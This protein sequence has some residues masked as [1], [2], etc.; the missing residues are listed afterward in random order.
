MT[1]T[2]RAPLSR[3]T[4]LSVNTSANYRATYYSR[5][6]GPTGGTVSDPYFRQYMS[7]HT[8]VVGPVFTR[9][10]DRPTS[11]FAER[12]KHVI[13]PAFSVDM[14]SRIADFAKTPVVS[15]VSEFVIGSAAQLT[16]G[17]TNRLFARG[18]DVGVTRGQTREFLTVGIQQT[19]YTNPDSIRYDSAYQSTFGY[20]FQRDRSPVALTARVSPTGTYRRQPSRG[21]RHLRSGATVAVGRRR[22]QFTKGVVCRQLQLAGFERQQFHV[23]VNYPALVGRAGERDVFSQ[24]G[25]RAVLRREPVDC[26]LVSGA[27]LRAPGRISEIQLPR[28]V[29]Y[30]NRLGHAFQFRVRPRRSGDVLEL[31]RRIRRAVRIFWPARQL[32]FAGKEGMTTPVSYTSAAVKHPRIAGVKTKPLRLIPDERGW[33]MEILRADESELFTKFGQVYVSA[34]YPGVVKA[35][36]YHKVQVDNFACIAGMVKLVL[37]D[38]RDGSP[39]K[40]AVNEFFLGTQNLTLVQVP[41]LVYHGWKCISTDLS[42]VINVPNEPYHYADPDEFRLAPHNTLDYDWTRK[43]G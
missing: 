8:D 29:G 23:G 1:P 40:G 17:L 16:Y 2:L 41:N 26:R 19:T 28:G 27:V 11:V 35:W 7:M 33:L 39:T 24:L 34:T 31:L 4:F 21:V 6:A 18:K 3:L 5:S 42:M 22:Y 36:H 14:T 10:W 20:P 38:T 12:L 13:E 15:D 9:I 25:Y 32:A 30:S 37:V 43:D